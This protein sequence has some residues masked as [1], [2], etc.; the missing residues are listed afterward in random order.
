MRNS[1]SSDRASTDH[2]GDIVK[3]LGPE[4]GLG[5]KLTSPIQEQWRGIAH[6]LALAGCRRRLR[7]S[8]RRPWSR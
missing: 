5:C 7:R 6:G 8:T 3:F 1:I 2:M 4:V